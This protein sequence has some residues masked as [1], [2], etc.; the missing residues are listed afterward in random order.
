MIRITI[1]P[2]VTSKKWC[3]RVLPKPC[4]RVP[5]VVQWGR[6]NENSRKPNTYLNAAKCKDSG[7]PNFDGRKRIFQKTKKFSSSFSI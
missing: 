2:D 1:D 4:S 7:E 5:L 6:A 3:A